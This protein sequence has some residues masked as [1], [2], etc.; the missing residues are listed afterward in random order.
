MDKVGLLQA[1]FG[2]LDRLA[3]L[4]NIGPA[5][6]YR[7]GSSYVPIKHL[8]RIRVLSEGRLTKELLRP[9][10]FGDN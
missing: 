10:L 7:W 6:V 1:E 4:L 8:A 2:T 9:D 5:N 3:K